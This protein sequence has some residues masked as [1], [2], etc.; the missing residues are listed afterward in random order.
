MQLGIIT[1]CYMAGIYNYNVPNDFNWP[2]MV[3]KHHAEFGEKDFVKLMRDIKALGLDAVEVWAPHANYLALTEK[4]ALRYKKILDDEGMSC[5]VYCVGGWG[6]ADTGVVER[7]FAF[8]KAL[9]SHTVNGTMPNDP[10]Q[11]TPILDVVDKF[12]NQYGL[13]YSIENHAIPAMEDYMTVRKICDTYS[14]AIGANLD[15]G[16]YYRTGYDVVKAAMELKD[17]VYH[18]HFKDAGAD[19]KAVPAG[20]GDAPL[21]ELAA[22]LQSINYKGMISIEWEPRIDPS[23]HLP[24]AVAYCKTFI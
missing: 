15:V 16:I 5:P 10:E 9:G 1:C 4:D 3:A 24:R 8:A 18:V 22:Y 6:K 12:G 7:G 20:E 17:R 14:P 21:K 11:H 2:A 23:P 19:G 13:R